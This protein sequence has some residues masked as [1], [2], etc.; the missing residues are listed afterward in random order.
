M[1]I[2]PQEVTYLPVFCFLVP[3]KVREARDRQAVRTQE[4]EQQQHQKLQAAQDREELRQSKVQTVQ[5]Q[6]QARAD[7]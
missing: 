4:E 5:Q 3:R 1:N 6:R 2:S 7:A